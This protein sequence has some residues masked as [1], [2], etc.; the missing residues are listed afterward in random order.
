MSTPGRPQQKRYEIEGE[1]GWTTWEVAERV[2]KPGTGLTY[3]A[4]SK[5]LQSGKNTWAE[6][7]RPVHCVEA[8]SRPADP[9]PPKGK[10]SLEQF[11]RLQIQQ[12]EHE[13]RAAW[14]S[15]RGPVSPCQLVAR[16]NPARPANTL[17]AAGPVIPEDGIETASCRGNGLCGA[18][19]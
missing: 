16:I 3:M 10:M 13:R 7:G 5:R 8:R 6:L 4:V 15:W 14:L 12:I 11:A 1:P 9:T 18:T 19:P 17:S 2:C